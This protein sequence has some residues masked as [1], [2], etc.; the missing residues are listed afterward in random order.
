MLDIVAAI[1]SKLSGKGIETQPQNCIESR[2]KLKVFYRFGYPCIFP[3]RQAV[4]QVLADSLK[5]KDRI[6]L[7]QRIVKI[8]YSDKGAI[9]FTKD[10]SEYAGDLVVGADGVHSSV[11]SEMWRHADLLK[12]GFIS[13]EEKKGSPHK[14]PRLSIR[15]SSPNHRNG[16]GIQLPLGTLKPYTWDEGRPCGTN[17]KQRFQR[18]LHG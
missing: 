12:P 5:E 14:I 8:E 2:L 11:R 16:C 1:S 18:S 17:L 13:T 15:L 6:H 7:D 3:A 9:V 4:L 10:G